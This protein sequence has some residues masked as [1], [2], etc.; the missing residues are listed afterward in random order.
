[1][2]ADTPAAMRLHAVNT[3]T[4]APLTAGSRKR[5]GIH[6]HPVGGPVLC[7]AQ[8]LVGDAIGNAKHH[9]GPDQALYLY[10]RADYAWWEAQLGH[11]CA[12]GLFGENLCIEAWWEAPRVGDRVQVGDV[13]LELTAPRIPC[14][15]LAARMNDARFVARFAQ[16][17]RPGAY[18][19]VLHPGVLEAGSTGTVFRAD[20]TY[21]T[22]S[23]LFALWYRRPRDPAPLLDALR[24]PVARRLR[25]TFLQWAAAGSP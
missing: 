9:G 20:E 19:R 7:D 14:A 21:P 1:M 3:G 10:S 2:T 16:A 24:A 23:A 8:G 12:P 18:A 13:V 5:S 22:I 4:L 25:D 17:E 11:T 15:T 6:K